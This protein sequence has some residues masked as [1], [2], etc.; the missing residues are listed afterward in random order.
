MLAVEGETVPY[1]GFRIRQNE[2]RSLITAIYDK[3]P[4]RNYDTVIVI[5]YA[6]RQLVLASK[7]ANCGIVTSQ[8]Y[9]FLRRSTCAELTLY[10]STSASGNKQALKSYHTG[11]LLAQIRQFF[12][13]LTRLWS[14][15]H[16][17]LM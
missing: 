13:R 6:D 10:T 11:L 7:A 8:M 15:G 16:R 4:D 1:M 5:R 14:K 9:H 17:D 2:R 3:R 12:T